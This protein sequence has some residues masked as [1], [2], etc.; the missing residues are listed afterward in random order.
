M[1]S[2]QPMPTEIILIQTYEQITAAYLEKRR[3]RSVIQRF[4]EQFDEH[5][6]PESWILDVGCGPGFDAQLLR[7]RG[8]KVFGID[9]CWKML[10]LGRK[11]FPGS[12]VQGDMRRFPLGSIADGLWVN[13]SCLHIV[14]DDV[15][16][17]LVEFHRILRDGGHLFMTLK[18]GTESRWEP[19]A[20]D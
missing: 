3:D 1:S 2:F 19:A 18:E 16:S 8:H 4:V 10:Q 13:A 5:I 9:L 20:Y 15:K 6:A 11:H 12:F 17:T 14:Q 7:K